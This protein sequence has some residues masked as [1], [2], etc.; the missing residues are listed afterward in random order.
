MAG[1]AVERYG[2]FVRTGS[3]VRGA[4]QPGQPGVLEVAPQIGVEV[5]GDAA[6]AQPGVIGALPEV[7]DELTQ[8]R[9]VVLRV[10]YGEHPAGQ[11]AQRSPIPRAITPRSTSLVPPR[12]VNMGL[13]SHAVVSMAATSGLGGDPSSRS[14]IS[15]TDSASKRGT[16]SF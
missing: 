9:V 12:S 6:V 1:H 8:L 14:A 16:R 4:R 10:G 7:V 11:G 15:S 2:Q 5:V 3:H 13:C